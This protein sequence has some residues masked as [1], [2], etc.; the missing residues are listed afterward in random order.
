M[1]ALRPT[2]K[3]EFH[4]SQKKYS[5]K[6]TFVN[7]QKKYA[8][9]DYLE[10]KK[11]KTI[12]FQIETEQKEGDSKI[13]AHKFRVGDEITFET[14]L[15]PRGDRLNATNLKFLY[16]TDFERLTNRAAT[17]NA[18]K[19]Y[20]K[21]VDEAWYIKE[22][23]TYLFFPLLLSKWEILPEKEEVMFALTHLDKPNSIGA[24]LLQSEFIPEYKTAMRHF[25]N[26]ETIA[27]TVTKV[28]PFAIYVNVVGDALQAKLP[29]EGNENLQ[30][31]DSVPIKITFL[32]KTKIAVQK[33]NA[34]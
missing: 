30:E 31:G 34:V 16:N 6:I 19:G 17:H 33:I 15:T 28:T 10:G 1:I 29:L 26:A 4:M 25:K 11:T 21:L 8:S 32:S 23:E 22:I 3:N 13:K 18:F 20:M 12:H 2:K 24:E 27:A 5:G 14:K 9:I 7:H